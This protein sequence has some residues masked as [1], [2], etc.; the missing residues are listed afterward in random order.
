VTLLRI[1]R[2]DPLE[3]QF[4][5][6]LV[7]SSI[8]WL[9]NEMPPPGHEVEFAFGGSLPSPRLVRSIPVSVLS[10]EGKWTRFPM[11]N[12]RR[13]VVS[14]RLSDLFKVKRGVATGSNKFFI[15]TQKEITTRRLPFEAFRPIL[16][17]PRH[18]HADEVIADE[19]GEPILE[20]KLYLLHC[21][22]PET[23]VKKRY[24]E[25][26]EYLQCG[27]STVA[28]RYLCK[29]RQVW[30]YQE[31]RAPAPIL[32]TY[33]G[34]IDTKSGRPFR[35]I[36][37][38]SKAIA[39]NVYLLLYPRGVLARLA[40]EDPQ[41]IRKVWHA[42]NSLPPASFLGEG[43][44]YGGGLHKLEPKEL[45]NVDVTSIVRDIPELEGQPRLRQMA[46]FDM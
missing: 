35:F 44:V 26:W 14:Y 19:R 37:N 13:N 41:I 29:S 6:A 46:L 10:T 43:R 24:P 45:A 9:R 25:L 27:K 42:L 18:L 12:I 15:L 33:L 4:S 20:P 38:H 21:R 36:L 3:V 39:A 40:R 31:D 11:F 7:S 22:L 5:D 28:E 16:P 23:E 8:L 32:C 1:H 2:F 34:R 17:S 30:Y